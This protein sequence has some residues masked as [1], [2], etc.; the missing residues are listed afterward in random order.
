M[1]SGYG[2]TGANQFGIHIWVEVTITL[3]HK[4]VCRSVCSLPTNYTFLTLVSFIPELKNRLL[5]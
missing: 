3:S 5:K 2:L 1:T 4:S